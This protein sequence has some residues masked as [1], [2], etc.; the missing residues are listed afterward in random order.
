MTADASTSTFAD[1]LAARVAERES[2]IVLGLDPDPTALWPEAHRHVSERH[3]GAPHPLHAAIAVRVHCCALIDAAGAACVAVKPQ[4]ACFERLGTHGWETLDAVCAHARN[5][6]LLVIA[7]GKRGDIAV[8]AGAYAEA[9]Y[10]RLGVNLATVNPLLGRDAL[11]PFIVT[12]RARGAGVLVLV[13]TSNPGAA[14]VQDLTLAS[15][16]TVWERLAALVSELGGELGIEPAV[17]PADEYAGAPGVDRT[18][19]GG[20]SGGLSDVGAVMGATQPQHLERAR[21]LMPRAVLLLP[22]V[23]AQGG[24]VDDLAAAFAPGRAGGLVTASRSI[25][26]AH[27]AAGGDPAEAARAEAERLRAAAWALSG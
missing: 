2:Q 1:T 21:E 5:R 14:D 13:R 24:R 16:E 26:G 12:A 7:D 20:R 6:G 23:G 9:L 17:E 11:E 18:D 19:P 8:S 15:G 27:L 25:A 3:A 4:L 22:G 10:E